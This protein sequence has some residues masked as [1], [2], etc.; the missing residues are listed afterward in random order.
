MKLLMIVINLIA[1]L[2]SVVWMSFNFCLGTSITMLVLLSAFFA[3]LIPSVSIKHNKDKE[4]AELFLREFP[5]T[6]ESCRLLKSQDL[7]GTFELSTLAEIQYFVRNWNNTSHEFIIKK[8]ERQKSEIMQKS[9]KFLGSLSLK[10]SVISGDVVTT[11]FKN[12]DR[13][14]ESILNKDWKEV[15]DLNKDATEIYN[16]HQKLTKS[17]RKFL[18]N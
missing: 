13:V 18:N 9:K 2:L 12:P 11:K 10:T 14:K 4:L 15:D 7:H 8:F 1:L 17:L 5:S 3:Q 16:M 6:G